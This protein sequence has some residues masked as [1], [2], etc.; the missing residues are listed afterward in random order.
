M[1][2]IYVFVIEHLMAPQL[3]YF[4]SSISL[5]SQLVYFPSSLVYTS[6]AVNFSHIR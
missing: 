3:V 5:F 4:P 1:H 2:S 6:M